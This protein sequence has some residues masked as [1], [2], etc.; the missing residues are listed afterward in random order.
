M[1]QEWGY[2]ESFNKRMAI[3]FRIEKATVNKYKPIV[4][5]DGATEEEKNNEGGCV[6]VVLGFY[7]VTPRKMLLQSKM[8]A[9]LTH[10]WNSR[11]LN[12]NRKGLRIVYRGCTRMNV[13]ETESKVLEIRKKR[14]TEKSIE[15]FIKTLE[16]H[17][18]SWMISEI[19]WMHLI[20]YLYAI[21]K[22]G[23]N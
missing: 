3:T 22:S 17:D 16:T 7:I 12:T 21:T 19:I 2:R 8:F 10:I 23:C 13:W 6:V 18:Q 9:L 14:H 15:L 11:K 4:V 20:Q 5:D 1:H